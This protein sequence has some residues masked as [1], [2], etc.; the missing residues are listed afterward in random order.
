[1]YNFKEPKDAYQISREFMEKG[2]A[3]GAVEFPSYI[4]FELLNVCNFRCIMC[5][6][7]YLKRTREELDFNLFKKIIDEISRY[8]SLVRFIGYDEPLL[9]GKIKEAVAYIKNKGLLLHITTNGSL[10]NKEI[11]KTIIDNKVDSVIF[12]FQG[13]SPNEYCFMRNLKPEIYSRVIRNIKLLHRSRKNNKPFMK[14][15]TTITERDS[16]ADKE[17]FIKDHLKYVDE[18]QISGFTHF[19]DL[20]NNFGQKDIWRKLNISKPRKIKDVSC[21]TPNYEL[22]VKSDGVLH[23]CCGAYGNDLQIGNTKE[24]SLFNIWHSKRANRIRRLLNNG[25]LEKFKTCAFCA[26]RYKYDNIN[27][28]VVDT[29]KGEVEKFTKQSE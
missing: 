8:G 28:T 13:L 10:L 17:K 5:I 22:L 1:M 16:A 11:I 29:R 4:T 9:Y 3:V 25:N 21:F 6:G 20:V 27:S 18:I 2:T 19:V 14:I 7:S 15:T 12:S 24:D 23:L 26:I